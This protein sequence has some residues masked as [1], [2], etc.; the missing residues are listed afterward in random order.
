MVEIMEFFDWDKVVLEIKRAIFNLEKAS[1]SMKR[2]TPYPYTD[3]KVG[4][5]LN[6]AYS[7]LH[8]AVSK[9][10]TLVQISPTPIANSILQRLLADFNI[11]DVKKYTGITR[12]EIVQIIR[13]LEGLLKEIPKGKVPITPAPSPQAPTG[14]MSVLPPTPPQPSIPA[15]PTPQITTPAP[16]RR[17]PPGKKYCIKCGAPIPETARFCPYCGA[18][19]P[20]RLG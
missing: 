11:M 10:Q 19:Q 12:E 6:T 4:D 3:K 5:K 2:A 15:R 13:D 9:I 8:E 17:A 16:M 20:V 7:S 1:K 18:P 14:P